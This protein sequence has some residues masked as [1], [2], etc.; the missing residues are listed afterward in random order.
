ML[1]IKFN[2]KDDWNRTPFLHTRVACTGIL[3]S[4]AFH[5]QPH[6]SSLLAKG[7]TSLRVENIIIKP[8]GLHAVT[9]CTVVFVVMTMSSRAPRFRKNAMPPASRPKY[10]PTYQRRYQYKSS[11]TSRDSSR[12][13][14]CIKR[15]NKHQSNAIYILYNF[16]KL[17]PCSKI[18]LEKLTVPHLIRICP[19]LYGTRTF[20]AELTRHRPL[21][22]YRARL[23]Q[24]MPHTTSWRSILILSSHLGPVIPRSIIPSVYPPNPICTSYLPH[25]CHMPH[26]SY[27]P[28]SE[29]PNNI[30]WGVQTT[31]LLIM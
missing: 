26:P 23:I 18:P 1:N 5:I 15:I 8:W 17:T 25:T 28:W 19:T 13:G 30:W 2:V 10:V 21:S 29:K 3:S 31:K 11:S 6:S 4:C 24:S 22:T 12:C 16:N 14:M 9:I 7:A 27:Y 20:I